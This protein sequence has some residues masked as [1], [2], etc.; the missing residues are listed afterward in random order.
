MRSVL[1]LYS[2]KNKT[3]IHCGIPAQ[4][5]ASCGLAALRRRIVLGVLVLIAQLPFST[6]FAEERRP[7]IV[8][9]VV[10]DMRWDE[11]SVAGHPFL[12]TPNIDRLAS[13]G[14]EFLNA[15]AVSPL[16]SP[17][18]A[19]LLT[20]QYPSRHGV[21]DNI[22]R[23]LSSFQL[24]LFARELQSSGYAT[25][26]IGKWQMGNDP[27]PRPG[28]DY[29]VSYSG[30]GRSIDPILY[31]HGREAEVKGYITD[32]LTER[33]LDFISK[34]SDRSFMVYLAHKAVHPDVKQNDDSSV[35]ISSKHNYVA[36]KR[37]Q[38]VY[39]GDQYRRRPNY[40]APTDSALSMQPMLK[41]I[42]SLKNAP[43]TRRQWHHVLDDSTSDKTI[44]DRSEM[45]MAV[46]E[47]VGAILDTLEEHDLL[48]STAIIFTSDN[49]YFYG[50][51]GLSIE[52]RMPYEE[53]VRVP[54]LLRY[55]E[56]VPPNRKPTEFAL[57][58]DLASTV[59]D[60]AGLRPGK[61][62]QGESLLPI[63]TDNEVQ[64]R[65]A[66]LIEHTSYDK[67]MPW[68][69]NTSYR[70]IRQKNFKYIHW[71]HQPAFNEFYD[72]TSDPFELVNRISDPDYKTQLEELQ[73]A[74]PLLAAEAMGL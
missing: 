36:A 43:G 66:F 74:L 5:G 64:W 23:D 3:G 59:L 20:G 13:E 58:I 46:D 50:E 40:A 73:K 68:L 10:D 30:Q 19:S 32:V 57:S 29:W 24:A 37:H 52:R 62:R 25:A 11:Y 14:A 53:G 54:L 48:D 16:C 15:Y 31:E 65:D 22:A 42:L 33:T 27:S 9:I 35:D 72:L 70:V 61:K 7:N 47:S 60:L 26:H 1:V 55:P 38:G 69:V 28:Y 17:N 6:I 56:S 51:H 49:G 45:L 71:L 67:P 63:V 39:A 8:V 34:N 21:V 2:L 44:R 18:R 12:K 4:L 41:N